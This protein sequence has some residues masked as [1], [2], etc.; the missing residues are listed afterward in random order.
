MG[1]YCDEVSSNTSISPLVLIWD[2][3]SI[4]LCRWIRITQELEEE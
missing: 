2:D 4:V 1:R 3:G